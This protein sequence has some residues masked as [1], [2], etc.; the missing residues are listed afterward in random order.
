MTKIR[1]TIGIYKHFC[2][3]TSCNKNTARSKIDPCPSCG[4]KTLTDVVARW[5][6][7][8]YLGWFNWEVDSKSVLV[9]KGDVLVMDADNGMEIVV[10]GKIYRG[11]KTIYYVVKESEAE[12]YL[13]NL[14]RSG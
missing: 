8:D 7:L 10:E 1:A 9:A 3:C 4:E 5:I 12:T 13:N 11:N 14:Y 2:R 6:T